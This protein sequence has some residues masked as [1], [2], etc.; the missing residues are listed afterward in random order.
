[1]CSSLI[2][3]N[4]WVINKTFGFCNKYLSETM[5]I[6]LYPIFLSLFIVG[7]IFFNMI[8]CFFYLLKNWSDFFMNKSIK[9]DKV[10]WNEP[11]T[12]LRPWRWF[13]FILYCFFLFF[14][15]ASIL[16]LIITLYSIFAPLGLTANIFNTNQTIGFTTFVKDVMIYKKQLYLIML[17]YVL[18][19]QAS[20]NLGINGMIGCFVGILIVMFFFHIYKQVIPS[21]DKNETDGLVSKSQAKVKAQNGGKNKK[22]NK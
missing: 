15:I 4:N 1:V 8:L 7:M 20:I 9:N 21:N 18:F 16:P 6:I 17:T 2:A 10:E 13:I 12:Y 14:P 3:S 5:I 22:N 19:S 11:F